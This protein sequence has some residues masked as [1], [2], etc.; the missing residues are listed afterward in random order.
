MLHFNVLKICIIKFFDFYMKP[1]ICFVCC[2]LPHVYPCV[3]SY[4]GKSAQ[5]LISHA[6]ADIHHKL[7]VVCNRAK[8]TLMQQVPCDIFYNSCVTREDGLSI[9]HT[10]LN[11]RCIYVPETYGLKN[12]KRNLYIQQVYGADST[13]LKIWN[14][15]LMKR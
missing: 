14:S 7:L 6:K 1:K 11:R 5:N 8:Q 15:K 13:L 2:R 9:Y 3:D 12:N 4:H 10:V